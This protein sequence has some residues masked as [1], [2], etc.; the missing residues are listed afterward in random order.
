MTVR[1]P[2]PLAKGVELQQELFTGAGEDEAAV[3]HAGDT[4]DAGRLQ[5]ALDL[6]QPRQRVLQGLEHRVTETGVEAV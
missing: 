4:E 5:R 1:T 6:D 3:L 2:E